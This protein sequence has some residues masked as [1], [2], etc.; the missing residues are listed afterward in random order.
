MTAMDLGRNQATAIAQGC[1]EH[2]DWAQSIKRNQYQLTLTYHTY[3]T[4]STI[5][6]AT[7]WFPIYR[8]LPGRCLMQT[9]TPSRNLHAF[10]QPT[11]LHATCL[12]CSCVTWFDVHSVA[13]STERCIFH[14][15]CMFTG[16][17]YRY[18]ER[19]NQRCCIVAKNVP[20]HKRELGSQRLKQS[21]LYS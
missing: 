7:K 6:F 14:I 21:W 16:I 15:L 17:N 19:K 10:T 9:W 2:N 3:A 13:K 1:S 12:I 18:R 11:C 20:S 8:I 4:K 5:F